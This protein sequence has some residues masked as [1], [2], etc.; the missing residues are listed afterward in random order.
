MLRERINKRLD[1]QREVGLKER[2][3]EKAAA[4]TQQRADE[5]GESGG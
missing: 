2:A 4:P 5:G 1:R 3:D